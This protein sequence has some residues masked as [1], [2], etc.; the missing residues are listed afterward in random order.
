MKKLIKKLFIL[1]GYQISKL[2]IKEN[3]IEAGSDTRPV[4]SMKLLLEDLKK[5]GLTC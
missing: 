5:R 4:G 1:A 2:K 3:T